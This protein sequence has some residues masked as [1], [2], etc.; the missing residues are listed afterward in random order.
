MFRRNLIPVWIGII[1]FTF[2]GVSCTEYTVTQLAD[3]AWVPQIN[4]NGHVVWEG[5][6]D[7]PGTDYEIFLYDGTSTTQLTNNALPN[8]PPR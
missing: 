5:Q 3:H 1:L 8:F 2:L 6:P 7:G 4:N